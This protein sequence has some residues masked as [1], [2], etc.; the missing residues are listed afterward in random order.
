MDELDFDDLDA[1]A[2]SMASILDV[3][4]AQSLIYDSQEVMAIEDETDLEAAAY[5]DF[6]DWASQAG[7]TAVGSKRMED[8]P[9]QFMATEL[10][11]IYSMPRLKQMSNIGDLSIDMSSPIEPLEASKFV[12]NAKRR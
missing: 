7:V 1:L 2:D 3:D 4:D 12:K 11:N 8:I 5:F 6:E 10:E 9:S